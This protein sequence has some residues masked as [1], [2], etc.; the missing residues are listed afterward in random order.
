MDQLNRIYHIIHV[1]LLFIYRHLLNQ[2]EF[3]LTLLFSIERIIQKFLSKIIL[4]TSIH[5]KLF[6]QLFKLLIFIGIL[7]IFSIRLYEVLKFIPKYP[8]PFNQTLDNYFD[9]RDAIS[10]TS[11]NSTDRSIIFRYCFQSVD[12]DTY[13]QI[14]SFYVLQ[15][16]FEYAALILIIL[17]SIVI[18]IQQYR[19]PTYIIITF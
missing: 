17:I 7:T 8:N 14:L 13:A 19:L 9:P 11:S 18:I 12:I 3:I 6:Q 4:R 10:D 15:Y 5:R 16:W 2:L 1:D